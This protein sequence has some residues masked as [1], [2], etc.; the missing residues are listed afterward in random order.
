MNH[1]IEAHIERMADQDRH[2]I[3]K[4]V[5]PDQLTT[6]EAH[7]LHQQ[8]VAYANLYESP[9]QMIAKIDAM[10]ADLDKQKVMINE[11]IARCYELRGAESRREK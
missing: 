11:M 6:A 1:Y 5:K 10:I 4:E 7:I 8:R 2:L 3:G 9:S